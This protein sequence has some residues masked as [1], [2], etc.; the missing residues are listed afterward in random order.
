MEEHRL[1]L[2]VRGRYFAM[3]ASLLRA[4]TLENFGSKIN[5]GYSLFIT[6][7]FVVC[8]SV[9][10]SKCFSIISL[11]TVSDLGGAKGATAP[12]IH[13]QGGTHTSSRKCLKK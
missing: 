3:A 6:Y 10:L 5:T 12:G 1:P 9:R 4:Q 11:L 2:D 8:D 13:M 7:F